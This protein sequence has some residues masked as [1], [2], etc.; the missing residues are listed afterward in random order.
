MPDF[1]VPVFEELFSVKQRT[2]TK[3]VVVKEVKFVTA[4]DD[5][6][7]KNVGIMLKRLPAP[8]LL[9]DAI[10]ELDEGEVDV[11]VLEAMM[12]NGIPKDEELA[13]IKDASM[14]MPDK[15][16]APPERFLHTV[17][18]IPRLRQRLEVWMYK[19]TFEENL[20][21]IK[22]MLM[23]CNRAMKTW[24]ANTALPALL[25]AIL[26]CGN[27]MNAGNKRT[28]RA[29]GF[30]IFDVLPSVASRRATDRKTTLLA[31][32]A[33]IAVQH[34]EGVWELPEQLA[35]THPAATTELEEVVNQ[36]YKLEQTHAKVEKLV[37][38]VRRAAPEEDA[39]HDT[40]PAFMDSAEKEIGKL[41]TLTI[42]AFAAYKSW[43]VFFGVDPKK[44]LK[45]YYVFDATDLSKPAA[46]EAGF[47]WKDNMEALS[48][49][50]HSLTEALRS[51]EALQNKKTRKQATSSRWQ[52]MRALSKFARRRG[53]RIG[54]VTPT[55][56]GLSAMELMIQRVQSGSM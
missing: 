39:F 14:N 24:K 42:D 32:A 48:G 29:D 30:N 37:A 6:R 31:F 10:L 15:P 25:A 23:T 49:F 56:G 53:A 34:D 45:K 7:S 13:A 5:N 17:G 20:A 35:C 36:V 19:Y 4:L 40:M 43:L 51:A 18:Q 55:A 2:E 16:L 52:K 50:V 12:A 9:L 21:D 26:N 3:A 54:D 47:Q 46:P 38:A 44:D 41:K 1:N 8:Q 27:F 28:E 22:Q 11:N 33:S